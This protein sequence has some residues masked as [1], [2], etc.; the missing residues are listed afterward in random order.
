MRKLGYRDIWENCYFST[1]GRNLALR[2]GEQTY[3]HHG[4]QYSVKTN[5]KVDPEAQRC[6]DW[7]RCKGPAELLKDKPEPDY[8]K[9][10]KS[11]RY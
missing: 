11:T 9:L 6:P 8:L 4:F 10:G 5:C 1:Y 2:F 7:Y 3:C